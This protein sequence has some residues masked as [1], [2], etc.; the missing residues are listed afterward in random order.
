MTAVTSI[1][2]LCLMAMLNLVFAVNAFGAEN[3][4]AVAT[5]DNPLA[6]ERFANGVVVF[7][8]SL[9]PGSNTNI[10]VVYYPADDECRPVKVDEYGIEGGDP[11]LEASFIYTIQG[12][13]NLFAIVSWPLQH[14]GLGMHGRF[15]SVYAYYQAG[16]NLELNPF[17]AENSDVSGGIVGTVEGEEYAFQGV[18]EDGLI[19]LMASL[20]KWSWQAACD[21]SGG[22]PALN[23]CVYVAQ[24]DAQEALDTLRQE[25]AMQY[26]AEPNPEFLAEVLARF[27]AAQRQWRLQVQH[28]LEALFPVPEGGDPSLLY[29][30]AYSMRYVL[31]HTFLIRQ[32][33]EFLRA[34]WLP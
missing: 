32:R 25:L 8:P 5:P 26:S 9:A 29:G 17:I 24:A 30:S 1:K 14:A 11:R 18:D 15:Y 6:L 4:C 23:A 21:P 3:A 10:D 28:D 12:E 33:T 31:A 2:C 22:Q 27:D 20:G 19:S 16:A 7:Q 34:M 13:P